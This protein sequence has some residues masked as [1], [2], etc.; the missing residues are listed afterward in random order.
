MKKYVAGLL[1]V[2]ALSVVPFSASGQTEPVEP[3][4]SETVDD[5]KVTPETT[6]TP[7]KKSDKKKKDDAAKPAAPAA[8]PG[9]EPKLAEEPVTPVEAAKGQV[10]AAEQ[11]AQTEAKPPEK[12]PE[13]PVEE[14]AVPDVD[15][16]NPFGD[17]PIADLADKDFVPLEDIE[18]GA[19]Q[20]IIPAKTYPNFDLTG[21]FRTRTR[22][23]MNWDLDTEGTSAIL[24][25]AESFTPLGN[26]VNPDKD[27]HWDANLRLRIEPTLNITEH[28][29]VVM[30]FHLLDNLNFGSL[31]AGRAGADPLTPSL[32]GVGGSDQLSP[33]EREFFR[34][35]LL[36]NELYGEV[37][38]LLGKLSVGRMDAHWGLGIRANNG[39]CLDCDYGS[40]FERIKFQ[41]KFWELYGNAAID[42][43]DE[44]LFSRVVEREGGQPYD[45]AQIDDVDQYSVAIFRKALT[46]EEKELRGKRLLEDQIP[47]V[48]GGLLYRYRR[49]DGRFSPLYTE[50][51]FDPVSPRDLIYRGERLHLLD[52][53]A[54][55]LYEPDFDTRVRFGIEALTW[56]G[57]VDNV[58]NSRVGLPEQTGDEPINCFDKDAFSANETNCTTDVDGNTTRQSVRQLG[59]ALE[60][61]FHFGGP[62]SFGV[63]GGVASG[64]DTPNWGAGAQDLSYYRFNP[65]YH[66]D[67]ILFRNVIG[68]VTNAYYLNPWA[69][70]KFLASSSRHVE[71]QIDAIGSR[72]VNVAG[73]PSGTSP[74]L[75][76]EFDGAVRYVN[77]DLFTAAIEAGILFPFEGLHAVPGREKY[78]PFG[79]DTSQ[80]N[81]EVRARIAWTLQ[82]KLFWNF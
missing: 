57:R 26:P 27:T 39:D 43:P 32:G 4:P 60:S 13:P 54:E 45:I 14:P 47:E 2:F 7:E 22:A 37:D 19:L 11:S 1:S 12:P 72:A 53:W 46:R 66:V 29:R 64:G 40:N 21:S 61:E 78:R 74:W 77:L 48:E 10:D 41:T 50:E 70:M 65:D 67:L 79:V 49:Q 55:F 73:T 20:Q 15:A 23:M 51:P 81:A 62:V 35:A 25:P 82:A 75:G 33:R 42:F 69:K 18:E 17:S 36:I 28:L 9:V 30:E 38:T 63:D 58:T 6:G 5:A 76:T 56:L 68:T 3:A 71:V 80:F 52:L 16:S 34:D 8:D 44:G 24:P 59:I 31:P